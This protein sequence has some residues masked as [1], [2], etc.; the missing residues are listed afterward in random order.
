MAFLKTNILKCAEV[1]ERMESREAVEVAC[2]G[3]ENFSGLKVRRRRACTHVQVFSPLYTRDAWKEVRRHWRPQ[4]CTTAH[5]DL[6]LALSNMFGCGYENH[7]KP[8]YLFRQVGRCSLSL[9]TSCLIS[10]RYADN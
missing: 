3:I 1:V 8:I 9:V 6:A 4:F 7:F 5:T 2:S 10:L